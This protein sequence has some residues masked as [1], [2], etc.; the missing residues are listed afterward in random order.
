MPP[1]SRSCYKCGNLGHIAADCASSDRLCYN[2]RQGGHESAACPA[3]RTV[4]TRQCYACGGL[5]APPSG[6]SSNKEEGKSAITA[7]GSGTSRAFV[8]AGLRRSL[9]A[10][11]RPV[12]R[13][14]RLLYLPSSATGAAAPTTWL[15]IVLLQLAQKRAKRVIDVTRKDTFHEE[16]RLP[17][18]REQLYNVVS[19]VASYR[20]FIP[21]CTDSRV[22]SST[23]KSTAPRILQGQLTVQFLAFTETYVSRVTCVPLESVEAVAS[24]ETPL[25]QELKTTWRFRT[26]RDP[27]TLVSLDLVY[28]FANPVYAALSSSFFSQVSKMMVNAFED[29]CAEV[30]GQSK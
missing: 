18:T 29:R 5:I 7:D 13:S 20:H 17:Y 25:F 23:D 26:D 11:R 9:R 3:P 2:C 15:A 22:L 24:S 1:P 28:A 12:D 8:L 21:F 10:R 6:S 16:K 4:A 27:G 30:Y 19:D 14:T